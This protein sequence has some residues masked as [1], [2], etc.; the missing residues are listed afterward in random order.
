MVTNNDKLKCDICGKLM[1]WKTSYY[2]WSPYGN[3]N[4]IEPPEEE[5]AHKKCYEAYDISLIQRT[6]WIKPFFVDNIRLER[7]LKLKK[8]NENKSQTL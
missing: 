5:H 1:S 8:L 6:S 2:V 4:D 7:K 3:S